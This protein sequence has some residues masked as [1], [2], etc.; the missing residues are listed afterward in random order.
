MGR[1]TIHRDSVSAHGI[2]EALAEQLR[3][4]IFNS[5][6]EIQILILAGVLNDIPVHVLARR[7]GVTPAKVKKIQAKTF[8]ALRHPSRAGQLRDYLPGDDSGKVLKPVIQQDKDLDALIRDSRE[9]KY[10]LGP[11]DEW[12]WGRPRLYCSAACRQASYR[13]RHS[14]AAGHGTPPTVQATEEAD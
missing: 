8:S 12:K 4:V 5:L 13:A 1:R 9:C 6:S 3:P 14:N 2:S 10:C 11:V 7:L